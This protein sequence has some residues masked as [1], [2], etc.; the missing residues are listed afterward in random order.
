[1]KL[2]SRSSA[3]KALTLAAVSALVLSGCAA[4]PEEEATDAAAADFLA[5]A[6]SDEGSWEDKS[7]N[8]ATQSGM[9]RAVEELEIS[10]ELLRSVS[11]DDFEPNLQTSVDAGCDVIIG[12]GYKIGD[13]I[14][15]IG[16]AN[17]DV[18]FALI[19]FNPEVANV[20]PLM[21]D[22]A[23][24]A[25]LAGYAAAD[26]STSKVISTYGG[27]P[28]PPVTDFMTGYYYGAMQWGLD[29]GK[30]VKVVGWDPVAETGDFMGNF[31]AN[32]TVSKQFAL[33]H[34]DQGADVIM[35]VAGNQFTAVTTSIDEINPK[36][37][38]IGVDTD[39]SA[40]NPDLAKYVF[41]S[42][43]KR[44]ALNV[45]EVISS[46]LKK[47]PFDS[48]VYLGTLENKGVGISPFYGF[49][50]SLSSGLLEK[51]AELETGIING[52]YKPK[53]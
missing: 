14:K 20:K 12:V 4:A 3:A 33:S 2:F 32:S 22:V 24:A 50:A 40:D 34:L 1:V 6:I 30:S 23:Q 18:N 48:A 13:A 11:T 39:V 42:V 44:M 9:N 52:T 21:Y 26:Y 19:D 35:P 45:F 7:F 53:G 28:I 37:V 25:F 27:I 43:E 47:E 15:K 8:Q 29:N 10:I 38:M 49:E 5:C 36:A 31:D 46:L 17:P 41:T 16:E 51:L